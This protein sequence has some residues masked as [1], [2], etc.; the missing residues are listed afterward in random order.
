M[1]A[2]LIQFSL[3]QRLFVLLGALML[4]GAGWFAF[5]QLP[6]DAFPDVSSTQVKV[7]MKAPGMT[8]EEVESRI[9]VPIEVEMLGIPKTKILRS[10]TK[11][12]LVDVT[13]D[14]EDGTDRYWARQQVNER[15]AGIAELLPQG[16]SGGMAPVTTPLGEMFMF[17]IEADGMSLADKR[18]LLDWVIRPALRTVPGVADV[19]SLGGMVRSFEIIPDPLKLAS[20]GITMAQLKDA[21]RS[22][23]MN[24]GAGR[25][26][27]GGEVLLVRT[28]GSIQNLDDL[29]SVV[30][31]VKDR[32]PVRVGSLAEVRVGTMTRNGVV[33]KSGQGEAV[34]GLVLGLAGANAQ[35]V[36]EGV[37]K[38]LEEIQSTLPKGVTLDVFYDR[39]SLVDKAVGAVSRA[40]LEATILVLVLLG[41][42][43]GNVRAAVTVALV[44]PLAAL[45]T[46]ILMRSFDMSANLMSLGGL[47]IAIGMLVDAAVVVTENIVQRLADDKSDG[48]LPRLHIVYRAVKE[49][50]VPVTS[51]IL[52]I[53]TV[54]LPLLTLQDLEGKFFAPVA[55]A[56]V[57]ALAGSLL[58]SFTVIPVIASYLIKNVS[59]E[60]PWLPRKLLQAYSPLL[61][62]V[63]RHQRVVSIGAVLMLA[64]AGVLYTQVGKTFMP[65]MDEGSLIVGIEKLPS[66]SLEESAAIDLKIHQ[67]LMK[68]IPEVTGVVARA[69]SDEIGLDPM[70]LNQT[71]T[72]L[73]LKP[74]SEWRMKTKDELLAE[75]RKVLD[76]L[77]GISYSFTQPIEMRVSEMIIGVRGDIAVKIFGP[78]LEQLNSYATQVEQVLK[79]ISGNQD[80]YTVQNDGVQYMRVIVDRMQA[81][82]LGLSVEDVQDALRVQI[83]GQQ[84]GTVIEGNRRT[85]ILLRASESIR[86]SP[87]EFS[88]V[89]ITGKDG[90]T[91]PLSS[92]ATLERAAGPVKIDREM[93]SRY[94]VVIANVSGRDL[95]GFVQEAQAKV[96]Q[97]LKLP[98]GYRMSWG[99]QFENQQRA[100]ARLG[101]V[102]PI[103]LGLIFVLLFATFGSIRQ[104]LL[105]LSIIPFALVGGIVAL[106]LTGE[107]LS[108]PA[109]V[110]F[111]A[112]LGITVLNGVVLVGYFNQLRHEG[113]PLREV[114]VTGAKRRLRPVMMTASI[115]AFGLIPLLFASG[116]GSEIQ[117]PLAIVVIGGLIT[118]TALTLM[119]L[120][121]LYLKFAGADKEPSQEIKHV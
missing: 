120:P 52:I 22:N 37:K 90:M 31:T 20:A 91:V 81:G 111:I 14:F 61:E 47:T 66:V 34:Q 11:Y 15:L 107:Y 106:W 40:L 13:I 92:I 102:V 116:P 99:G 73:L 1:L 60:E 105:I 27:E 77:P 26:S 64:L 50:A 101:V 30:V 82:R 112:L 57:F 28:E 62:W 109:S 84:T 71:D 53:I 108:V 35:K 69:G 21:L 9:A 110:G 4:A 51:G 6:I 10:V 41:L 45:I 96:A 54:F 79:T 63:L 58:L 70:G 103:S 55:M 78:D 65:T 74:Q 76:T 39:A 85:P 119:L 49:V 87:A 94:S 23:N 118:A 18:S 93:G 43:L 48:K 46:F 56:I 8:P 80:V 7:I 88:A 97:K 25:L 121:I 115:T 12:G 5:T 95:V 114:V 67:A 16:I 2:R 72:Y 68:E 44:L 17:T 100:A 83:E 33:T 89:R 24:D 19:N 29:R 42:F 117:R 113:M 3:S 36:V 98:T 104:A 38:K 32:S 59:H 75:I 86:L